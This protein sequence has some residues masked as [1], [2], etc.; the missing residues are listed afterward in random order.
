MRR[1]ECVRLSFTVD[2]VFACYYTRVA[3]ATGKKYIHV[4]PRG[5]TP[6]NAN[7]WITLRTLRSVEQNKVRDS[8]IYYICC[9]YSNRMSPTLTHFP[10]SMAG[11]QQ[12]IFNRAS[13]RKNRNLR[14]IRHI[15]LSILFFLSIVSYFC[16]RVA[17]RM[18]P[19][20]GSVSIKKSN[21]N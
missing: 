14:R 5:M 21:V 9:S 6:Q 3:Y 2:L 1:S 17:Q 15:E 7:K 19:I 10:T 20:M 4:F 16:R 13:D 11:V 12:T 18:Y 8:D